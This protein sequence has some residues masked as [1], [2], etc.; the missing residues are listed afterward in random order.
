MELCSQEES[1]QDAGVSGK[2]P[3]EMDVDESLQQN[4]PSV[5][6]K[7]NYKD[8]VEKVEKPGEYCS[9]HKATS[10]GADHVFAKPSLLP[11][12]IRKP[13]T[14]KIFSST[15][16][17][18]NAAFSKDLEDVRKL[19]PPSKSK[20]NAAKLAAVRPPPYPKPAPAGNP[21]CKSP[22]FSN[23]PQALSSSN[24]LQSQNRHY[25]NALNISRGPGRETCSFL[26]TQQRNY[27]IFVNQVLKWTYEMFANFSHF[28]TPDNLLQS[29]VASVP[30]QFQDYDDYFNTFFPLMMLNAFE[31]VSSFLPFGLVSSTLI[32]FMERSKP[33][34]CPLFTFENVQIQV[35]IEE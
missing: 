2:T 6:V 12:K 30:V 15:S 8:C 24:V 19:P 31:T 7:C 5:V 28:G 3:E 11:P 27:S 34:L 18:R 9:K 16:S 17:S 13:S 14:T 23:V 20:V 22:S 25:D 33:A 1:V 35:R 10:P 29:I 32:N 21:T 26:G 4:E